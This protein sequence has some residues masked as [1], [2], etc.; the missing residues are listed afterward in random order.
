M[1][2]A[3]IRQVVL[4]GHVCIGSVLRYCRRFVEEKKNL[5]GTKG[6]PDLCSWKRRLAHIE[7]FREESSKLIT[8][9]CGGIESRS[10]VGLACSTL[11]SLTYCVVQL[12]TVCCSSGA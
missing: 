12:G 8:A 11:Q 6:K 7:S 1:S 3:F 2:R 5:G 9:N 10:Y 4:Q